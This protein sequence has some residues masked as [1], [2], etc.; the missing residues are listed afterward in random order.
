MFHF[1]FH[2]AK[3]KKAIKNKKPDH[4]CAGKKHS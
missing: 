2:K 1:L 4:T 3:G